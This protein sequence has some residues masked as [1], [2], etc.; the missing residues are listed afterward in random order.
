MK[1]STIPLEDQK[2]LFKAQT[3]RYCCRATLLTTEDLTGKVDNGN[4]CH[5]VEMYMMDLDTDIQRTRE[6]STN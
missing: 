5:A 4:F 6:V 3:K 2:R 1:G